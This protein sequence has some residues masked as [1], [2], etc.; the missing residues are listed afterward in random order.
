MPAY[1]ALKIVASQ[2]DQWQDFILI[3]PKYCMRDQRIVFPLLCASHPVAQTE[4]TLPK[5]SPSEPVANVRG[6]DC[7][8]SNLEDETLSC[9]DERFLHKLADERSYS[10]WQMK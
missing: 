4:E 2:S 10:D 5:I 8:G 9:K 3:S 6:G 1:S 7:A